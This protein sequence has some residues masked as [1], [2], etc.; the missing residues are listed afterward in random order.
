MPSSHYFLLDDGRAARYGVDDVGYG[1][2]G[3]RASLPEIIKNQDDPFVFDKILFG[4]D[5]EKGLHIGN[6]IDEALKNSPHL[7]ENPVPGKTIYETFSKDGKIT[8]AHAGNRVEDVYTREGLASFYDDSADPTRGPSKVINT[9]LDNVEFVEREGTK[10]VDLKMPTLKT[11]SANAAPVSTP[12]PATTPPPSSSP[13]SRL[14]GTAVSGSPTAQP[15]YSRP[16]SIDI[17]GSGLVTQGHINSPKYTPK[18]SDMNINH[19]W[20][21]HGDLVADLTKEEAYAKV[22]LERTNAG[23]RIVDQ[24]AYN[25]FRTRVSN[26]GIDLAQT[27]LENV[28]FIDSFLISA[29]TIQTPIAPGPS[30]DATRKAIT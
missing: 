20:K 18:V 7:T 28:N 11:T 26:I 17:R 2:M 10:I 1:W 4:G 19:G 27:P 22:G 21:I 9:T 13:T 16:G 14:R 6:N 23:A 8:K 12:T 5:V 30:V 29:K 15:S 25:A 3:A 24:K